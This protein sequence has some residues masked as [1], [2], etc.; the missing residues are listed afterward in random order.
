[1]WDV[2]RYVFFR[3]LDLLV[4]Q[5]RDD[6]VSTA[7]RELLDGGYAWLA[8]TYYTPE[9]GAEVVRAIR[10]DL[11]AAVRAAYPP[12]DPH[13][14]AMGEMVDDLVAITDRWL[15]GTLVSATVRFERPGERGFE[16]WEATVAEV[17]W[18]RDALA[19]HVGEDLAATLAALPLRGPDWL[20]FKD[21][22]EDEVRELLRALRE[23]VAG[24]APA[25]RREL[26]AELVRV[27]TEWQAARPGL[28]A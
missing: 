26:I 5:L 10:E 18:V 2:P 22:S 17:G 6:E 28:T 12:P 21:F 27:A 20:S 14:V 16:M 9:Q 13:H 23:D 19:R 24:E 3:V 15:A 7:L 4:D 8:L 1:M 11:P 25:D